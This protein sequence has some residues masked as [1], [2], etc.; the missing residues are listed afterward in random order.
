MTRY[1]IFFSILS[2]VKNIPIN[3]AMMFFFSGKTF[4]DNRFMFQ[5]LQNISPKIDIIELR[6]YYSWSFLRIFA[7]I[8]DYNPKS[9]LEKFLKCF[10]L[11]V[12]LTHCLTR[13]I[14]IYYKK[15]KCSYLI[16]NNRFLAK[17]SILMVSFS[18]SYNFVLAPFVLSS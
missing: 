16:S 12:I 1:G 9:K 15:L 13:K 4:S 10:K 14:K 7:F 8:L 5:I 18:L 17:T 11:Y 2:A 3:F 6:C